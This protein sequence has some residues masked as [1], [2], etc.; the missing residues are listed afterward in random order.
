M[1]EA[2]QAQP[3]HDHESKPDA[4]DKPKIH[5]VCISCNNMFEVT[6]DNYEEKHCSVCHKA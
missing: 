2:T 6:I 1:D 4:S 3:T 5:R